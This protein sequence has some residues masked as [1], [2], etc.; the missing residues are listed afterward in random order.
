MYNLELT[1]EY[2]WKIEK[3]CQKY[4]SAADTIK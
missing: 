1:P 3:F 4:P 2:F